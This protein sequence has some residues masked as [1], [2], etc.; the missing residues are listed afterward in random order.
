MKY[1]SVKI[2]AFSVVCI[3]TFAILYVNLDNDIK[4]QNSQEPPTVKVEFYTVK[5]HDGKIAVYK[6][7][8]TSPIEIYDSYTSLLPE[9]DKKLLESGIVIYSKEELQRIIEDYTS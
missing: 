8:D 1:N 5:E 9:Y 3:L 6:N 4:N 7:Y 2:I